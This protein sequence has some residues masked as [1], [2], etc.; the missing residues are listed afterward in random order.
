[1]LLLHGMGKKEPVRYAFAVG[2]VLQHNIKDNNHN[3]E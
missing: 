3:S 1:M 2:H